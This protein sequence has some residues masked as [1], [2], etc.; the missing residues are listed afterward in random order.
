[1]PPLRLSTFIALLG[2]SL[3]ALA[4][5][6]LSD[7]GIGGLLLIV[8]IPVIVLL[9]YVVL[10]GIIVFVTWCFAA[11]NHRLSFPIVFAIAGLALSGMLFLAPFLNLMHAPLVAWVIATPMLVVATTLLFAWNSRKSPPIQK[12]DR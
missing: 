10:V 3:P 12:T 4:H 6:G 2:T 9:V 8:F 7:I 5:D 11:P 1:M